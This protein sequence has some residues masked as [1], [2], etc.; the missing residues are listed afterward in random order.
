MY[1]RSFGDGKNHS[2][3]SQ[4]SRSPLRSN[5]HLLALNQI[6]LQEA[7]SIFSL[8]S[9]AFY[10]IGNKLGRVQRK[11]TKGHQNRDMPT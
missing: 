1:V 4:N 10:E 3:H 8:S 9:F 2:Q 5:C 7:N 6:L 11:G